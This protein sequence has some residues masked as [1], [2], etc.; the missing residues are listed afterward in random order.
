MS[1]LLMIEEAAKILRVSQGTIRRM[2]SRGE[3][4]GVRVGRL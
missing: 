1:G 4:K 2:L 3:L